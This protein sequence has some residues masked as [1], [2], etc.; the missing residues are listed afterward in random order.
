MLE[1]VNKY[2][3]GNYDKYGVL[4]NLSLLKTSFNITVYGSGNCD[5]D[6]MLLHLQGIPV[7]YW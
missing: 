7:A 5:K 1:I 6:G 4:L 3:S 2:V